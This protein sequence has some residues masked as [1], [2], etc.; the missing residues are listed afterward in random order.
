[1][2]Y[3]SVHANKEG[4]FFV[5]KFL[6]PHHTVFY[7]TMRIYNN[8]GLQAE[9][10]SESVVVSQIKSNLIQGAW[11]YSDTCPITEAKWSVRSLAGKLLFDNIVIPSAGNKFYNDEVQLENGMKYIVMVQT[12]DFLGRVKIAQSDGVSVRIQPPFPASVRDGID[13]D[14]NYQFSLSDLQIRLK[15]DIL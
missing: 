6:L 5:D 15:G 7:T 1:V 8:A 13:Q 11:K 12:I 4:V 3:T 9:I 10:T 2:S 14:I